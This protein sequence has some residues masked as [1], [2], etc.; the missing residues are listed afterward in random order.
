V[1]KQPSTLAS[2]HA[3]LVGNYLVSIDNLKVV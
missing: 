2:E 3:M 1:N